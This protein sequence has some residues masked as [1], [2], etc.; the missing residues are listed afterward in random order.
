MSKAPSIDGK[1]DDTEWAGASKIIAVHRVNEFALEPRQGY[2]LLSYDK[3][4]LYIAMSTELPPD[5]KLMAM[6]KRKSEMSTMMTALR[7]GWI[8]TA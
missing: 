1:I 3:D 6:V 5:G 7:Y 8:R 4:N 2:T